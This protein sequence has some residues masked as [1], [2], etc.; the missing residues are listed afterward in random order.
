MKDGNTM[1]RWLDIVVHTDP[2]KKGTGAGDTLPLHQPKSS[3]SLEKSTHMDPAGE[4][5]ARERENR[6]LSTQA[7]L[8][9]ESREEHPHRPLVL[10]LLIL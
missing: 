5:K 7:L 10:I 3:I 9:R 2:R 1:R 6:C 4:K 8:S